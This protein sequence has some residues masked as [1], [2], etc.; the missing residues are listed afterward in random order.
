MEQFTAAADKIKVVEASK[1]SNEDKLVRK[2]RTLAVQ[3]WAVK[4][5]C[6]HYRE[7]S[8]LRACMATFA[9]SIW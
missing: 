8:L 5:L 7:A 9:A 1:T 6:S 4:R 2:K 3:R